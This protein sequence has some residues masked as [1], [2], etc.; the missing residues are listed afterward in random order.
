MFLIS[1]HMCE[2]MIFV[3]SFWY[4]SLYM[5]LPRSIHISTNDTVLFLFMAE[6]YAFVYKYHIFLSILL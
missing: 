6:Y 5:I 1:T 2:Y 4:T 3:F